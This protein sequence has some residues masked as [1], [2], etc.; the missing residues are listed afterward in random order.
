MIKTINIFF[1]LAVALFFSACDTEE[2]PSRVVLD[3]NENW[4]FM[5]S[6]SIDASASAYNDSSWRVLDLPHD[7]SIEGAFGKDNPAGTGGGA[8]P[9]GTGWYRK[10]FDVPE[11]WKDKVVRMEFGGVYRNSEVWING[12]SL[13]QRANG[14]ISFGYAIEKYLRF[15]GE[16]NVVTVKADNS[17]Q[18][19]SRWYTGSGIYRDVK[20]VATGKLRIA[21][22]GTYV[23]TPAVSA[24]S[25]RVVMDVEVINSHTEAKTLKVASEIIDG[26]GRSI[27]FATTARSVASGQAV[28]VQQQMTV[29]DPQLWSVEKP[30]MYRVHTRVYD[31]EEKTDDYDTP[32]G[33][34]YFEFDAE[35][36]FSL[37]GKPMKIL[38][39]CLHHDSGALGAVV[40][41]DALRR[42]LGLMKEMGANAIRTA[43]NPH[44]SVLLRLCDEMGFIVQ[45]EAFDSWKKKKV[46]E[47]YHT[48]W[49]A[50]HMKDLQDFIK[51]DRN[52]PSVM[53]WSIGNEIREQF[54]STGITI[55]R[56]LTGIVKA[57][58]TTRPVTSALTE[59][60]PEKNFIYRSGALDLLGFN[61]KIDAYEDLPN[62]FPGAK[63]IA[64]ENVSGL[65]T[66][67]SYDM[68]SDSLMHWPE[69]FDAPFE[70]HDDYTVSAY[71]QVTAYWGATHEETWKVVK[72][73][74]FI[75]GVF[76]WSG[77]DF[78]GEPVPYPDYPARSSY[79]GIVDLAG[80]PKDV[81][82]MYKSEWTDTP[83]LHVF[84]H[85]NWE[86]GQ[87][88]D[89]WAYYNRADEVEL[90]LN[91][92]S[93][94]KK[95]K[96][97]GE[98]HVMWRVP[99]APG[100]LKAVSRKGGKVVLERE[101]HTAGPAEKL[102]L[103]PD[104]KSF[105][106]DKKALCFVTVDIT[107]KEGNLVPD[108]DDKIYF[109]VTGGARIVGVD[110][111]YQADT[112]PM[113][114]REKNAF[115]GKCLVIL[116]SDGTGEEVMLKAKAGF[117]EETVISIR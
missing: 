97:E 113:K 4:K 64:S 112:T 3:F 84:P 24:D 2:K 106:K 8:L 90:F 87:E 17:R 93:L 35:K 23:T 54:D 95:S 73:L 28:T 89:V 51:R 14:Y 104:R 5:L 115:K 77:I 34:R 16:D 47:D 22:Q 82:Y 103:Q 71:D 32:L 91:G 99:F 31:G 88:V 59:N 37:N 75:S 102:Q 66:R 83:V 48:D 76:I 9:T 109:E 79:Y 72:N 70:G 11:D 61:Y 80:F 19:N 52:H 105:R 1:Y 74:D 78:L 39:V 30:Y 29:K 58:D 6:D 100:T 116:Q 10:T 26:A 98:F 46:K 43:H 114:A 86:E 55:T 96:K 81:Y 25:A 41:E 65:A 13:G 94:G 21:P 63:F 15:N 110:N 45:D 62:R 117:G 44:S 27:A 40:Y 56:E 7:W 69:A 68:P 92:E 53:M 49:D 42:K 60:E 101:I 18:P 33:I 85:W 111:G 36:G 20:L 12:H 50:W 38:G 57:L 108:A 67:G 107:D